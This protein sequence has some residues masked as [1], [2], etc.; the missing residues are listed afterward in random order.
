MAI[1]MKIKFVVGQHI[2]HA[3]LVYFYVFNDQIILHTYF[4]SIWTFPFY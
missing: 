2:S 4:I 3:V 1:K